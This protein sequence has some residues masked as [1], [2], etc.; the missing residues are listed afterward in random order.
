M[1]EDRRKNARD[2]T[3]EI[4]KQRDL[5]KEMDGRTKEARAIQQ[6]I[7][8][9]VAERSRLQDQIR[10]S[11]D[12]QV[13]VGKQV[14]LIEKE[15]DRTEKQ[16][17]KSFSS[18][19]QSLAK[20]NIASALGLSFVTKHESKQR[21]LALAHKDAQEEMALLNLS[22]GQQNKLHKLSLKFLYSSLTCFEFIIIGGSIDSYNPHFDVS[23]TTL[24]CKLSLS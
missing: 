6:T 10:E 17:D 19:L 14:L 9:L 5:L 3:A 20:G 1:A 2:Y 21:E 13:K 7:N 15:L 18:R 4:R 16:I 12:D 22:Q 24:L 11:I 8:N 23:S